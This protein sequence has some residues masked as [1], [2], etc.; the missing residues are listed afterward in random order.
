MSCLP[1]FVCKEGRY[2]IFG[3][4]NTSVGLCGQGLSNR[5]KN[6]F[7]LLHRRYL[8]AFFRWA[9]SARSRQQFL[10]FFVRLP[11]LRVSPAPRSLCACLHSH[12]KREQITLVLHAKRIW[13]GKPFPEVQTAVD[14]I[15]SAVNPRV[16]YVWFVKD[17]HHFKV[18]FLRLTIT[19][20]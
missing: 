15:Y 5:R 4:K 1:G 8:F 12:E 9:R 19:A 7:S 13:T 18:Y 14:G 3:F 11:P 16:A 6:K 20:Y 2:V 10:A 17:D